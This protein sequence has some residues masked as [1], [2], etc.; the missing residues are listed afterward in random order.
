MADA[1]LTPLADW[2]RRLRYT[3]FVRAQEVRQRLDVIGSLDWYSIEGQAL[4]TALLPRLSFSKGVGLFNTAS[5]SCLDA[6]EQAGAFPAAWQLPIPGHEQGSITCLAKRFLAHIPPASSLTKGAQARWSQWACQ[7]VAAIPTV[8][9][10]TQVMETHLRER[11]LEPV[12]DANHA[13]VAQTIVKHWPRAFNAPDPLSGK[14]WPTAK[15]SEA[16][17]NWALSHNLDPM[18]SSSAD[19]RPFWWLAY[20]QGCRPAGNWAVLNDV[21]GAEAFRVAR[22]FKGMTGPCYPEDAALGRLTKRPDWPTLK[23]EQ[24]TS[25][26][27]VACH[28]HLWLLASG[29]H[30]EIKMQP[31]WCEAVDAQG[32]NLAFAV[33]ASPDPR[34]YNDAKGASLRYLALQSIQLEPDALG[35]GLA[36]SWPDLSD[37]KDII[38]IA[39]RYPG[40]HRW[41]QGTPEQISPFTSRLAQADFT[42]WRTVCNLMDAV[43]PTDPALAMVHHVLLAQADRPFPPPPPS[44]RWP[45]ELNGSRLWE[46]ARASS[47]GAQLEALRRITLAGT[48]EQ[49]APS[50]KTR[51]RP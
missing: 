15:I 32:R 8:P 7:A 4:L 36:I 5:L 43:P 39:H 44:L 40:S 9:T 14:V 21:V 41:W 34:T 51:Q 24:G 2:V 31:N 25:A 26:L 6:L 30:P 3:Q 38:E 23:N 1:P 50:H 27:W 37:V 20:E 17:W 48:L 45:A 16:G 11:V 10:L 29:I 47:Q 18:H 13:K 33:L 35:R 46:K 19:T 42:Q 49:A 28:H 12:I 22:Y